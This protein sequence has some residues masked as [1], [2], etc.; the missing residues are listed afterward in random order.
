MS[1]AESLHRL[2]QLDNEIQAAHTQLETIARALA[3]SPAVQHARAEC[4]RLEQA[5]RAASSELK[6]RELDAQALAEKI[7]HEEHRLYGGLI[8]SPKEI[9]DVERELGALRRRREA[10]DEELL[11][12]MERVEQLQGEL[13]QCRVA[14]RE[15]EQRFAEDSAA[16]RTQQAA[17][18]QALQALL[19]RRQVLV[20][21][22]SANVVQQYE[23]LRVRKANKV[24]VALVR[25]GVCTQCGQGLPSQLAQQ[26][27]IGEEVAFCPNCGR[28]LYAP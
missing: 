7:A 22:L 23:A 14:L 3:D 11:G 28:I 1:L 27:R 17:L 19:E 15:A 24:A 18:Q 21:H 2:Q 10:L 13:Q 26:A 5:L 4:A 12:L 16:L 25:D 20:E 8:R 9:L 6:L